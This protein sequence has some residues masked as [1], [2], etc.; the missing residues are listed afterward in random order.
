LNLRDRSSRR[1]AGAKWPRNDRTAPPPRANRPPPKAAGNLLLAARPADDYARIVPPLE[2]VPL[3]LKQ[4]LTQPGTPVSDIYF[5]GDGFCSELTVLGDGRMVEVATIGREGVVGL[6]GDS[7]NGPVTSATMVQAAT[8]ASVRMP[9]AFFRH[10]MNR[11]GAFFELVS[12]YRLAL[13]R[14][15][16]QST[17]CNAVHTV[18]ERLAR[19]LLTA[20]DHLRTSAFPLTQEFAAMMLGVTRPTVS[21]VAATL[22]RAGLITYHRGVVTVVDRERLEAAACECYGITAAIVRQSAPEAARGH[23][24]DGD[25]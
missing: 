17:A 24:H 13:T 18:E 3:R 4:I 16:M 23:R 22:Q 2:V 19:W 20:E 21:G 14:F 25:M 1:E 8:S 9:V 11:G 7:G 10:E 12:R 5:P 6:L 15:I